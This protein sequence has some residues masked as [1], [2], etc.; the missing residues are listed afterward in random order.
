MPT[1]KSTTTPEDQPDPSP[2]PDPSS[3]Q[4]IQQQLDRVRDG[5]AGIFTRVH[6]V[7]DVCI[8]V[9]KALLRQNADQ[10]VQFANVLQRCGSDALYVQLEELAAVIEDLG[11]KPMDCTRLPPEVEALLNRE[12]TD[13]ER[14]R[15]T[16]PS[17]ADSRRRSHH[18]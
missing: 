1:G 2:Q 15:S 3:P 11:G 16:H 6:L 18:R 13:A 10:D 14:T 8:T 17:V 5:L 4:T 9:H 12:S 7:L